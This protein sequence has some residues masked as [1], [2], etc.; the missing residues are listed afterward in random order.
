MAE[1]GRSIETLA[2]RFREFASAQERAIEAREAALRLRGLLFASVSHD[3][4]SPLNAVLGFCAL[5]DIEPLEHGQRENVAIIER[6][7]RELLA[8]IETILDAA[9]IEA[10]QLALHREMTLVDEVIDE[11]VRRGDDL[12]PMD[13]TSVTLRVVPGLPMVKWGGA[14]VAQAIAALIGHSKRLSPNGGVEVVARRGR[15]GVEVLVEEP[16][17]AIPP[18]ELIALLDARNAATAPRRLGGLALGLSLARS[19]IELHGGSL[20]V[21][22]ANHGPGSVFVVQLPR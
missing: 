2:E 6:R 8:L 1:L 13:A 10:R 22:R 19:L 20:E 9:R 15:I 17:G 18:E 3:L 12:G 14:R 5:L 4:K 7:A 21:A 16:S 11:A